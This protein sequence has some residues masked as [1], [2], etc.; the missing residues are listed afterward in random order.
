MSILGVLVLIAVSHPVYRLLAGNTVEIPWVLTFLMGLFTIQSGWNNIYSF[1]L[2]G[3]SK[4]RL[5]VILAVLAALANIP[6][7][8]FLAGHLG[9]GSS[10]VIL[11]T[12]LCLFPLSIVQPIQY[13]KLIGGTATG[14]FNK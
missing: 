4:I 2:N 9:L 11:A 6:L 10:G 3:I 5:Q 7:S 8:I 13:S 1:F 14:I 12:I